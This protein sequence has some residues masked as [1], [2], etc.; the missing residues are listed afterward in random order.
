[1]NHRERLERAL[2]ILIRRSGSRIVGLTGFP[3][4]VSK[5]YE[6]LLRLGQAIVGAIKALGDLSSFEARSMVDTIAGA[7]ALENTDL[8][9][10]QLG[11]VDVVLKG[12]RGTPDTPFEHD[13]PP[14]DPDLASKALELAKVLFN[15]LG[16]KPTDEELARVFV[17]Q[18][19]FGADE[20]D[21]ERLSYLVRWTLAQLP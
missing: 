13:D 11:T 2:E 20:V 6:Q 15:E 5:E 12:M 14:L 10:R 9:A 8:A 7:I 17:D 4:A 18:G 19:L 1:M 16:R 3:E 21:P